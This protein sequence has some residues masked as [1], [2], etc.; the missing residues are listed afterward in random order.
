[1]V[2]YLRP[3]L[4]L[5]LVGLIEAS[6]FRAQA[7]KENP[8]LL[9]RQRLYLFDS[10]TNGERKAVVT[11]AIYIYDSTFHIVT[12]RPIDESI[13]YISLSPDG[14]LLAVQNEIWETDTLRPL[15]QLKTAYIL[16]DWSADGKFI[17]AVASGAN[18]I[19]VYD[20]HT[21][22]LIKTIAIDNIQLGFNPLWSADGRYFT[23]THR[24][25][26]VVVMDANGNQPPKRYAQQENVGPTMAWSHDGRR[27]AFTAFDEVPPTTPDSKPA[28][29]SNTGA[30]LDSIHIMDAATGTI[31]QTF[32][33][34]SYGAGELRW[35]PDDKQLLAEISP[36][37]ILIWDV[38]S[39]NLKENYQFAGRIVGA[40]YSPFGGQVILGLDTSVTST[41]N[42]TSIFARTFLGGAVGFIV[43]SPS[44]ERLK[45]ITEA[46]GLQA[47]V[48]EA[49]ISQIDANDLNTFKT[50]VSA[51]TNADMPAGCQA[52]LLAVADAL[53]A[54]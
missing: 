41:A 8:I 34:L 53:L 40:K 42:D 21:G 17:S 18:G 3:F 52:D 4:M 35:S 38:K 7:E 32:T 48:Q 30:V 50:Q 49:L 26:M 33:G 46:C 47:N 12:S 5:L 37:N 2:T 28:A 13:S 25:K 43:P 24:R 15:F 44:L 23:A 54:K 1:M 19:V 14:S 16:G 6:G 9:S 51:L 39:G 29:Y 36:T 20:T 27:I 31:Q 10:S 11:D 22:K 45:S